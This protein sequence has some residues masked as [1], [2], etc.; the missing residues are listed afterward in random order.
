MY[1]RPPKVRRDESRTQGLDRLE[2]IR[3]LQVAQTITVH[4]G[5][6]AYLL[7]INALRASEAAAVRIEDYADTL[8]GH[9]VLRLVGKGN[10]PATMPVTVPVLRVLEAWA[11][12]QCGHGTA[13]EPG[14][15]NR[16]STSS[17]SSPTRSHQWVTPGSSAT[18]A[19]RGGR[20][21]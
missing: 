7:A 1:A 15:D 12:R 2:L 4:Q 3:F 21:G 16:R 5:A 20:S 8:R 10:K 13:M 17:R 14:G 6:L 19:P 18:P 11:H 9:R